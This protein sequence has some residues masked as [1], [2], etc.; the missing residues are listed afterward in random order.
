MNWRMSWASVYYLF[1]GLLGPTGLMSAN[2]LE[3]E[4]AIFSLSTLMS[5]SPRETYIEF[6]KVKCLIDCL[7]HIWMSFGLLGQYNIIFFNCC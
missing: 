7:P 3:Q 6:E 1:Q 4:A 2:P 5:I